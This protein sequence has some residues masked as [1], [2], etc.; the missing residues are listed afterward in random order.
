VLRVEGNTQHRCQ[1][2][3]LGFTLFWYVMHAVWQIGTTV[4]EVSAEFTSAV[5]FKTQE[6]YSFD[7][8]H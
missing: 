1:T 5:V 7:M 4:L 6:A 3:E 2:V 8:T